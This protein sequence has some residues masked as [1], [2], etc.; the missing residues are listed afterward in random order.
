MARQFETLAVAGDADGDG[1]MTEGEWHDLIATRLA[2]R[3]RRLV[4]RSYDADGSGRIELGEVESFL[5][6]FRA[7]SVRADANFDGLVDASDLEALIGHLRA[8]DR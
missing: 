5:G 4:L 7:G 8:P 6:W 2:E 3:D 1:R